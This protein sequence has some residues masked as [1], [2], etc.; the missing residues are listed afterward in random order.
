MY[1]EG[2]AEF[3]TLISK[4]GGNAPIARFTFADFT[5]ERFVKLEYYG[6]S[7]NSDDIAIGTTNMAY[8]DVSA[9]TD[10]IITNQE[11]LFEVGMELSDGTVEYAPMGYFTV[12]KPDGDEDTINFTA[13]DRMQKFE[14]PY[15]STLTYPTD[16]AKVVNELCMMCGVEL[17]APITTPIT[18][19]DN[20]QGYTCCEALGYIAGIHGFFACIDRY[21]KLNLRWYSETPIK[22]QIGLIWSLTK[23]QSNYT[24]EKITLAKD[25][26]TT[27]TNGDGISG[28]SHSNP[29]ATQAIADSIYASL[30]G[31]TYRPCE[32]SMLDDIRLDPW[33]MLKVTYLDGSVLLIPVMSLSHSFTNG[34]T[35]I[36]SFGKSDTEN[37]YSYSGPVTQAMNRIA[38]ELL[39][40]NRIIATKVDAEYVQAHAITTDNIS[41][42]EAEI[43]KAVIEEVSTQYADIRLANI[44]TANIDVANIGLL[45]NKVGLIDRAT[46]VDGHI[47][48]YLDAVEINANSITAGTLMADR[49]ILKYTDESGK[50]KYRLFDGIDESGNIIYT[51]LN[52][53]VITKRTVTADTIV[54]N[55]I[56]A[57]EL[58]VENVFANEAVIKKIF[59]Q[60]IT[61]TGSI[62]SPLL[63][64]DD[65]KYT[66]A[67][68]EGEEYSDSGMI[69]DLRDKII[70]TPK[71]CL[72]KN[73]TMFAS[74]I[75][76][77]RYYSLPET[78]TAFIFNGFTGGSKNTTDLFKISGNTVDGITYTT[79]VDTDNTLFN[80]VKPCH[81]SYNISADEILTGSIIINGATTSSYP[82]FFN[83][84][85]GEC[86]NIWQG[87]KE[88][89]FAVGLGTGDYNYEYFSWYSFA[90]GCNL[91]ALHQDGF[92]SMTNTASSQGRVSIGV[93]GEGGNIELISPGNTRGMQMDIYDNNI[94][95]MYMFDVNPW[96]YAADFGFNFAEGVW[97][98]NKILRLTNGG[99]QLP[100]SESIF[101]QHTNGNYYKTLSCVNSGNVWFGSGYRDGL[102]GECYY[103]GNEVK[104]RTNG[105]YIYGNKNYSNDSDARLKHDVEDVDEKLIDAFDNLRPVTF[106]WN[107]SQD[108]RKMIG[109]IAQ[110][111]I[112]AFKKAD[113]DSNQYGVV[114]QQTP[115]EEREIGYYTVAY[116][117]LHI[118]TMA[119]VKSQ[120]KVIKSLQKENSELKSKIDNLESRIAKL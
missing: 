109:V 29:Y 2:S 41:A 96:S 67:T 116:D 111:V 6:G 55:S 5:V 68:A 113:V 8:L 30:D 43:K 112:E 51:T 59:A 36:K 92:L 34:E 91:M 17:A 88:N 108:G 94:F 114:M 40:A 49:L 118:L 81:F 50:T 44:D 83:T 35:K 31:F 104:L 99:L 12:Q 46:I 57:N 15:F 63:Q 69:V 106:V 13:Y 98:I 93:D 71:F 82:C 119:K 90:R 28:I 97:F 95:R 3:N 10:K 74:E 86:S 47:T 102:V 79:Y 39:I 16:S 38:T 22:K 110:E 85:T 70:R 24:V 52:G 77:G 65:Y 101:T 27:Y 20:L 32:I 33:D 107:D 76:G 23:S 11:F 25:G 66:G 42:I 56:T 45:F 21:G 48:G 60:D 117:N 89:K 14:K 54:A 26:E 4:S 19:T 72:T 53:D 37:E 9:I 61:A 1:N 105:S 115:D 75:H 73:G 100:N 87:N 64:S 80:F 103:A 62:T 78:E 84:N 120:D 58:D 18:I 7:N